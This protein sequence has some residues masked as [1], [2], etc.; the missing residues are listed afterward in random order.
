MA[1]CD[2]ATSRGVSH[3]IYN[4]LPTELEG[5]DSDFTARVKPHCDG[6]AIPLEE[7]KIL[8]QR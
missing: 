2:L 4:L 1:W 8:W 5:F 6:V 7:A 3:P